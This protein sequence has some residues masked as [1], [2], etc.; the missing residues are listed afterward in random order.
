MEFLTEKQLSP[1]LNLQHV[2][3]ELWSRG[4]RRDCKL[5]E[6]L[7]HWKCLGKDY[8]RFNLW[9]DAIRLLRSP[10][11]AVR[12]VWEK[13]NFVSIETVQTHIKRTDF[14]HRTER[15]HY[16]LLRTWKISKDTR[17]NHIFHVQLPFVYVL[18]CSNG[19]LTSCALPVAPYLRFID[20]VLI[21]HLFLFS[22]FHE[23]ISL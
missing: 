18:R 6:S 19:T 2:N 7:K 23:S 13:F 17:A 22:S 14:C 5:P 11:S 20:Y 21:K 4:I 3:D 1:L 9:W 12:K 16:K 15:S 10:G 8:E